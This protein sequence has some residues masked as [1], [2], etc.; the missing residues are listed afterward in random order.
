MG[1]ISLPLRQYDDVSR[2]LGKVKSKWWKQLHKVHEPTVIVVRSA[3]LFECRHAERLVVLRRLVTGLADL[4]RKRKMVS[5]VLVYDE[6]PGGFGH[7]GALDRG[8]FRIAVGPSQ[9]GCWR[10]AILV[11]N[12]DPRVRLDADEC[13]RLV[14]PNMSW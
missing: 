10:T 9:D 14:G 3:N 7:S 5:A 11:P 13:D 2:I 8:S 1:R 4:L 12:P 6:A